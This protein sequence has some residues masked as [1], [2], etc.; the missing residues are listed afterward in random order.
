MLL[1][2]PLQAVREGQRAF[3]SLPSVSLIL[4]QYKG[5]WRVTREE[6]E[7]ITSPGEEAPKR[8]RK[9]RTNVRQ[10]KTEQGQTE[11]S[12]PFAGP[13]NQNPP[14]NS[15]TPKRLNGMSPLG[16]RVF[17]FGC[18]DVSKYIGTAITNEHYTHR[19]CSQYR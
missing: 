13:P 5:R 3:I 2:P 15:I 14:S 19:T 8:D 17:N 7:V 16:D 6:M 1:I 9:R 10:Q 4:R 18:F 12:K 11:T